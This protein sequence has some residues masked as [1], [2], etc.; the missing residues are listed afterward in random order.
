MEIQAIRRSMQESPPPPPTGANMREWFAGL[1]LSNAEL[2]R[3]VSPAARAAEAVRLADELMAA[4]AMPRVPAADSFNEPGEQEMANWE[5]KIESRNQPTARPGA[6]TAP[7]NTLPPPSPG[8]VEANNCFRSATGS[9]RR[10]SERA[11]PKTAAPRALLANT[12]YSSLD[13]SLEE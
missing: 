13:S 9:L 3:D 7:R 2:M 12:R 4:L 5:Q 1:A 6:V 11:V 8:L 10:A